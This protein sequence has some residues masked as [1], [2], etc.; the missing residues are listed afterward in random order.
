MRFALAGFDLFHGVLETFV[1]AGW[2]AVSLFS[3]VTDDR[4]NSNAEIV[5]HATRHGLP[6]H[7]SRIDEAALRTLRDL[8]CDVLI[9]A[10][11]GWRIPDWTPYVRH[12]INFHPAPLPEARGPYPLMRAILDGHREWGVTC[13][14]IAPE[15]DTGEILAQ[16]RFALSA[17]ECH[18]SLQLKVQMAG[19]RLARQVA[20]RFDALWAACA[21]QAGG[22]RW[23]MP[24]EA[25]R[26]LDFTQPVARVMTQVRANGLHECIAHVGGSVLYVRRA[27]GWQE[28][29]A[30]EPGAIAHVSGRWTVIAVPDGFVALLEWSALS[31][32]RRADVGP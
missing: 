1:S 32:A 28:R 19:C 7:L 10:G 21:P 14:R 22:S 25:D 12:A 6:L 3:F 17:D 23:P 9:V 31:L 20:H 24:S 11:Y 27:V 4:V 8:D 13:H 30:C 2:T 29:H 5:S 26:T 15:F 18:E 16:E